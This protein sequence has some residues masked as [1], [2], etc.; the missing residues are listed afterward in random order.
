MT[1]V[2]VQVEPHLVVRERLREAFPDDWGSRVLYVTDPEKG[3]LRRDADLTGARSFPIPGNVGGR[4]SVLTPAGLFPAACAALGATTSLPLS[5]TATS[6]G[7][8][9]VH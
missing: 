3:P 4:F 1:L 8:L 5:S 6:I 2:C 9:V 7:G